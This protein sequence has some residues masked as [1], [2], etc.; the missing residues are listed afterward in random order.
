M[1]IENEKKKILFFSS[2]CKELIFYG[3]VL[4][5]VNDYNYFVDIVNIILFYF[6]VFDR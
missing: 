3:K 2:F 5:E 1:C 4:L 6:E